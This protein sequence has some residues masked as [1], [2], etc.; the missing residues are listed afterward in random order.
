MT[1]YSRLSL[2]WPHQTIEYAT[3]VNPATAPMPIHRQMGAVGVC[4]SPSSS[5]TRGPLNCLTTISQ[6]SSTREAQ[7]SEESLP[8]QTS[9]EKVWPSR[10]DHPHLDLGG[11]KIVH[12]TAVQKIKD[13]CSAVKPAATT[14]CHLPLENSVTMSAFHAY[15]RGLQAQW[16]ILS[17]LIC[18]SA[19]VYANKHA[20]ILSEQA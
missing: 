12:K 13:T 4:L 18:S 14:C 17:E 9:W 15:V 10:K 8:W 2:M 3:S 5:C 20:T 1:G 11:N 16:L 7:F 19:A 6:I